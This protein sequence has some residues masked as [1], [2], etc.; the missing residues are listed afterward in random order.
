MPA[1][2][3]L[4]NQRIKVYDGAE[5]A[6]D[7]LLPAGPGPFPTVVLRTPYG[8]GRYLNNPRGW[9]RMVDYGYAF[10]V[11]DVRGRNDSG[12]DWIPCVKDST[13]AYG[14]I[15][16]AARQAWSTGNVG[17]VGGSY[18]GL[19]QWWTVIGRPPH[20][21]CIAPQCVGSFR[22][23][24][25]YGNGIPLQYWLWWMNLVSGKTMQFSGAPSW[26][27]FITHLPLRTLDER[28][29][30]S[31]SAWQAYV[32][33]D[34]EFFSDAATLASADYAQ[35]D[36]PVLIGVG[37]W[38]D[39]ETMLAW[40][41]L[42]SAKSA[43]DCRLLIG[44]WDHAGNT[45]P[46]PVLGGLEVWAS[47][48]DTID[49]TEQFLAL[50][51]KGERKA[52]ADAPRCRVFLT[53]ENRW[54]ALDR[55]PHPQAMMMPWFLA[56]EGD[57]RGLNGNGR[58]VRELGSTS[59]AD[60]FVF[61]PNEPSRD[62]SSLAMF[63]WADPPLDYRYLQRRKDTLV[64]TSAVLSDPLMVSGRFQLEVYICSNRSDTDLYLGLS[65][66]HPDGRA[67]GLAP[68]NEPLS[69]LRLRYR[70]GSNP[71]PMIPGA[72]YKVSIEG[73]WV[74][75]VFKAGHRLRLMLHSGSF[76]FTVRNAGTGAHWA[77]G[78]VLHPQT[79]TVYHSN[80]YRSRILLPVVARDAH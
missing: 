19:T 29:G 14:V 18:D 41:A 45:A 66:V 60:S 53:G 8:R 76:P 21:R 33:G 31:R 67:I 64:Y 7:V 27:A 17:M 58:L 55:W 74:H 80:E 10:V 6:A 73:S 26:E 3:T 47:V 54:E 36:I 40:Q 43:A 42:Q 4:W 68:T 49:Y 51:L 13:D 78:T 11:V 61:D 69:G 62:M 70:D 59:D 2:R 12:G 39:Q 79:N 15:E 28:F 72:I 1:A 5:M 63:A 65:D 52:I 48:M 35:I 16:W 77:E 56:S 38:D 57:A 23:R 22:G 34:I 20:L 71:K 9:I 75:H 25:P 50:H 46:R 37:W 30:L 24:L 32:N 44:A